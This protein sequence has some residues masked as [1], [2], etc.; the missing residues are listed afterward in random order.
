MPRS[1]PRSRTSPT[2]DARDEFVDSTNNFLGLAWYL[3]ADR[4]NEI[5]RDSLR[6]DLGFYTEQSRPNSEA[7]QSEVR[8]QSGDLAGPTSR[9]RP[10]L[11]GLRHAHDS[12]SPRAATETTT[13]RFRS[14]DPIQWYT[15]GIE[16]VGTATTSGT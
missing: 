4:G 1:H 15:T 10:A 7:G 3:P 8:Q 12:E 6:F 5:Q 14:T 16:S 13:R 11:E 9:S 2:N